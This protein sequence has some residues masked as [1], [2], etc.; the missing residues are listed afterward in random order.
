MQVSA[1]TRDDPFDMLAC[2]PSLVTI[3]APK[4]DDAHANYA[5][6]D[7]DIAAKAEENHDFQYSSRNRKSIR[8]SRHKVTGL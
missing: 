8:K 2:L 7:T 3:Q 6:S 4:N 5:L 1:Q